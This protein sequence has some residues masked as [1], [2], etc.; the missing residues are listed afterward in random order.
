MD[1]FVTWLNNAP[2]LAIILYAIYLLYKKIE[3]LEIR[4]AKMQTKL[5]MMAPTRYDKWSDRAPTP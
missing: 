1:P 2:V 4:M 3:G 5:E